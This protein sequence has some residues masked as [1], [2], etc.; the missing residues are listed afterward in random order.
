ME[1]GRWW[2]ATSGG[3][4]QNSAIFKVNGPQ[5]GLIALK[6]SHNIAKSMVYIINQPCDDFQQGGCLYKPTCGIQWT[7]KHL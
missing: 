4:Q 2:G 5:G 6:L 7:P 1:G 3:L